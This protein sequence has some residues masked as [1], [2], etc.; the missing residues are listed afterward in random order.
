MSDTVRHD[1]EGQRFVM[2]VEG[3]EALLA[4][5][6]EGNI[7]DFTPLCRRSS[8]VGGWP[9][10]VVKDSFEVAKQKGPKVRPSCPYVS[11]A[12]LKRHQEYHALG[13]R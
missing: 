13:A 12:V 1:E 11:G 6:Q 9:E 7:L 5:S 4:Y 10:K 3:R 8:G 2:E